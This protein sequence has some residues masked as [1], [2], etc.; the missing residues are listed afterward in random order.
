MY[1]G[2]ICILPFQFMRNTVCGVQFDKGCHQQKH[3]PLVVEI[4]DIGLVVGKPVAGKGIDCIY[5][6][7]ARQHEENIGNILHALQTVDNLRIALVEL[8]RL[9]QGEKHGAQQEHPAGV[10]QHVRINK[11]K[12]K[13]AR[14]DNHQYAAKQKIALCILLNCF[15]VMI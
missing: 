1:L 2:F 4:G 13:A 8:H 7:D 3:H 5:H 12:C 15:I 9:H 10:K 11:T 14:T 6:R